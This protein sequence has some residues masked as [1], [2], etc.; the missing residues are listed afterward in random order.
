MAW[1]DEPC[2]S[3]RGESPWNP[4]DAEA[5]LA[6]LND[7]EGPGWRVSTDGKALEKELR[8]PDFAAAVAFVD[9]LQ[10][11]ADAQDHHPDLSV[12]YGKVAIRLSTH[13]I[14]GISGNDLAL[15]ARIDQLPGAA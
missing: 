15:A 1:I 8:F 12:G 13:S 14:G 7:H 11:V 9:R 3:R 10:P 2:R 4:T 6:A 5:E